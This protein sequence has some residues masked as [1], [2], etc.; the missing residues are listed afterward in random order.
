[1]QAKYLEMVE[2]LYKLY[3]DIKCDLNY[4]T[5]FQLL[6]AVMMSAQCTDKRVN[7]VTPHLF[8]EFPTSCVMAEAPLSRVEKLIHTTGFYHNK[9]KNIIAMSKILVQEYQGA[10]PTTQEALV[11]LPGVGRKTANVIMGELYKVPAV[12]VDTHVKRL[13]NLIGLS[14]ESDVVK[15]EQDIEKKISKKYWIDLTH[16]FI[17]HGRAICVARR[18]KCSEC[19]IYHICKTGK[20]VR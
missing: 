9:S 19:E 16:L 10:L 18:A 14:K 5:P 8:A 1:M 3:P 6:V 7:M 13:S 2:I 12:V 17:R 11:A 20:R 15:I 4:E